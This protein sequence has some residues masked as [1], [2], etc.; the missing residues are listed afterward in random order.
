[1]CFLSLILLSLL[2]LI[3]DLGEYYDV[4][5]K[6]IRKLI[7]DYTDS[8]RLQNWSAPFTATLDFRPVLNYDFVSTAPFPRKPFGEPNTLTNKF[9]YPGCAACWTRGDF[10]CDD[11]GTYELWTESGSY[12]SETFEVLGVPRLNVP[13]KTHLHAGH[14]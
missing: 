6:A 10:S 11:K 5:I 4:A 7:S 13:N 12:D 9:K 14:P 3:F 2:T 1:M 8:L